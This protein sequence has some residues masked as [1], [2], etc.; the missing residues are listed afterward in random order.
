MIQIDNDWDLS[1]NVQIIDSNN[2]ISQSKIPGR[3]D[4]AVTNP[5]QIESLIGAMMYGFTTNTQ[6]S[7]F[8]TARVSLLELDGGNNG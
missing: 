8:L 5:Q 3:F 2:N 7:I 1:A 6:G 4:P